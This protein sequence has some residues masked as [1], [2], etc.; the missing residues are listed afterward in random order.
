[1][2]EEE[3][4]KGDCRP[5]NW[6]VFFKLRF[7]RTW[8]KQYLITSQTRVKRVSRIHHRTIAILYL[9]F[10][11]W[12]IWDRFISEGLCPP[13]ARCKNGLSPRLSYDQPGCFAIPQ[14]NSPHLN[15]LLLVSVFVITLIQI[16]HQFV[17]IYIPSFCFA[18][19]SSFPPDRV[20]HLSRGDF[21]RR[22]QRSSSR[23]SVHWGHAT[24]CS[25]R[26]C[27]CR[28]RPWSTSDEEPHSTAILERSW[29]D[30]SWNQPGKNHGD[31]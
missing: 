18:S 3:I 8:T 16:E 12:D 30:T 21:P 15:P 19:W 29:W 5:P 25:T 13:M 11:I 31:V 28:N 14:S 27:H 9:L 22:S 4:E 1:M 24:H 17:R 26:C 2:K 7:C 6:K 23:R 10:K 20:R